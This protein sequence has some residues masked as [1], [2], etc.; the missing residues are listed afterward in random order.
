[1]D[2]IKALIDII[3][4]NITRLMDSSGDKCRLKHEDTN[5]YKLEGNLLLKFDGYHFLVAV[6]D[7]NILIICCF[8]V[9]SR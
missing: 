6:A 1:M 5:I 3:M 7:C 4:S 9:R 2:F 8:F